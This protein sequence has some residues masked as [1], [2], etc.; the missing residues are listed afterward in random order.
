MLIETPVALTK[1]G[2]GK[3]AAKAFYKYLWSSTAQK[4][5]AEQGYRPVVKSVAKGYHFYKPPGL[6]TIG[7]RSAG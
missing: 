3:P 2:L 5:F 4:A 6:F 7:S 1:T